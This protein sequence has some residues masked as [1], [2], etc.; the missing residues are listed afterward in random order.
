VFQRGERIA[1]PCGVLHLAKD[2][3][4]PPRAW[5]ERAYSVVHWTEKPK[6]GHFAAWEEPEVFARD[7]REFVAPFRNEPL[8]EGRA[9][10]M[11]AEIRD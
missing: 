7:V 4:M 1:V 5:V 6:G 3:P 2:E 11:R 8:R 9:R 10:I